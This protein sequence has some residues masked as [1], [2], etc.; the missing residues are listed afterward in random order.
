MIEQIPNIDAD[1][2]QIDFRTPV[3]DVISDE[4]RVSQDRRWSI[5]TEAAR[6]AILDDG[7][8]AAI[9]AGHSTDDL[10]EG[11]PKAF[12]DD[13]SP[14][15]ASI[16]RAF[17]VSGP[18][19]AEH[20]AL[21]SVPEELIPFGIRAVDHNIS[22]A[23]AHARLKDT[24]KNYPL[25]YDQDLQ[26]L[27]AEVAIPR[28]TTGEERLVTDRYRR[29]RD[30]KLL[31][32]IGEL[33][34]QK[35]VFKDEGDL[36]VA[37]L[38]SGVHIALTSEAL[39]A[40]AGLADEAKW[41]WRRQIKDR[42]YEVSVAGKH[43]IMKEKKTSRHTDVWVDDNDGVVGH[44]TSTSEQEFKTG[45]EFSQFQP[46]THGELTLT[47]EK[48]IGYA[49]FPDGYQFCLF[50]K[51][52]DAED[53][54]L[55][56][57]KQ[58]EEEIMARPEAYV[59]EYQEVQAAAT[60]FIAN[61]QGSFVLTDPKALMSFEAFAAAKTEVLM[62]QAEQDVTRAILQAGYVD[63]DHKAFMLRKNLPTN[64][65]ERIHLELIG[66]DYE[67]FVRDAERAKRELDQMAEAERS[68]R[69]IEN[70]LRFNRSN[71]GVYYVT[72]KDIATLVLYEK[73]DMQ[74][75]LGM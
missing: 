4:V 58:T 15:S 54:T 24:A 11:L 50:E 14:S 69:H 18:R 70:F 63:E 72:M 21:P 6:R 56:F 38:D 28:L 73:L 7:E 34:K 36:K 10:S 22:P 40:N 8:V 68:G 20:L 33:T 16:Q 66:M 67:F 31:S 51:I 2:A 48:P 1:L 39:S 12:I 52:E 47:W 55:K 30:V 65:S 26:D 43:Y 19:L 41:K 27:R 60:T 5:V 53:Y 3:V 61:H 59:A 13:L 25:L 17:A 42:V 71:D 44:E 32:L 23:D 9:A 64:P 75:P 37:E 74:L 57:I 49:E 35:P 46:T 29:A 45:Q 62:T